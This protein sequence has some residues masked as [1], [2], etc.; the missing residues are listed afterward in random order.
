MTIKEISLVCYSRIEY[1]QTIVDDDIISPFSDIRGLYSTLVNMKL[2]DVIMIKHT[3]DYIIKKHESRNSP[4][5]RLM[6]NDVIRLK[7]SSGKEA[8]YLDG[9]LICDRKVIKSVHDINPNMV[10]KFVW[11]KK[12]GTDEFVKIKAD[13]IV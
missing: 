3:C 12:S 9:K 6:E 13:R 7:K 8:T 2:G 5:Y 1:N 4:K 11:I 10:L